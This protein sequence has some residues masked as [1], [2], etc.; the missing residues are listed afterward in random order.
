MKK[1]FFMERNGVSQPVSPWVFW[2]LALP[3]VALFTVSACW[4]I[5]L[6]YL[7][8][9]MLEHYTGIPAFGWGVLLFMLLWQ[10][11]IT[12]TRAG[13]EWKEHVKAVFPLTVRKVLGSCL[14]LGTVYFQYAVQHWGVISLLVL[15]SPPILFGLRWLWAKKQKSL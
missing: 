12:G 9:H 15:V 7:C 4:A 6:I 10:V 5:W 3:S 2:R 1:T 8:T 14:F 11:T 13:K